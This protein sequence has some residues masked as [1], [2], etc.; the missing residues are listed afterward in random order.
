MPVQD[1]HFPAAEKRRAAKQVRMSEAGFAVCAGV[2]T[3]L[4]EGLTALKLTSF[5][6]LEI[7]HPVY[8]PLEV[9]IAMPVQDTDILC[10]TQ[11]QIKHT[12]TSVL[13]LQHDAALLSAGIPLL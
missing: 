9:A 7:H 13:F 8:N 11:K 12:V 1:A 2:S 6:H 5:F 3:T 4:L 10:G